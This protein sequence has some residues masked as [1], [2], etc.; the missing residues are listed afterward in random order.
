MTM[1]RNGKT[2]DCTEEEMDC[3]FEMTPE[4]L[5]MLR[6]DED[7]TAPM[8]PREA[9]SLQVILGLGGKCTGWEMEEACDQ[10]VALYGGEAKALA[11]IRRGD[12]P[13]RTRN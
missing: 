3:V 8:D 7:G 2:Y 9:L 11:A 5:V 1:T 12:W 10:I 13:I 4:A 6:A